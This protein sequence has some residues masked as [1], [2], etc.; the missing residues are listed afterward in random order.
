V[1]FSYSDFIQGQGFN[2][3]SGRTGPIKEGVR[4]RIHYTPRPCGGGCA[5]IW[6]LEIAE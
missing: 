2:R 3:T 4:L 1:R 5:D 6:K